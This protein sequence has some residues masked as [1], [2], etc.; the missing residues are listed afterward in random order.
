MNPHKKYRK[1]KKRQKKRDLF[2]R[3]VFALVIAHTIGLVM[4]FMLN[5]VLFKN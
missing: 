5:H 1:F 3:M 4:G 2:N